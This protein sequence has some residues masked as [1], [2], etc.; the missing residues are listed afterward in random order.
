TVAL[1]VIVEE[2]APGAR[3]PAEHVVGWLVSPGT[4][5]WQLA[6]GIETLVIETPAGTVSV[7]TTLVAVDGP[8]LWTLSV[9]LIDV[10]ATT[11]AGPFLVSA[12]SDSAVTLR[13]TSAWLLVASG[14]GVSLRTEATS[15]M[16]WPSIAVIV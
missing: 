15:S 4:P 11:V 12:R 6:L 10:P 1:I 8:E 3:L 5:A 13:L 14:S 2:V 7:I 9:Q 16:F